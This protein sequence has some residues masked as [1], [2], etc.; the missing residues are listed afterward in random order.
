V[1][2]RWL[3]WPATAAGPV[4]KYT[5]TGNLSY[6]TSTRF[7]ATS[8]TES[9]AK[10]SEWNVLTAAEFYRNGTNELQVWLEYTGTDY[11]DAATFVSSATGVNLQLFVNSTQ[12]LDTGSVSPTLAMTAIGSYVRFELNVS[13]GVDDTFFATCADTDPFEVRLFYD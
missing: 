10:T 7:H 2:P 6:S 1:S 11:A 8:I 9:G 3:H 5:A 12:F 13:A 4:A